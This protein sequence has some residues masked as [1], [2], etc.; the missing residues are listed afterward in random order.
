MLETDTERAICERRKTTNEGRTVYNCKGCPLRVDTVWSRY[1]CKA[2]AHYNEYMRE[3]VPDD[4]N[5]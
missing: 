4:T 3:W 5:V 1:A 2:T